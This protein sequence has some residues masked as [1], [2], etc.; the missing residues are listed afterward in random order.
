MAAQKRTSK[1][2]SATVIAELIVRRGALRRFDKLKRATAELPVKVT[3]DRR[4][5]ERRNSAA[6]V[7]R[8]RRQQDRRQAPPFTW[9]VADFLVVARRDQKP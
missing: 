8:E 6:N 1:R 3:W 7:A 4:L 9:E 5:E 2:A